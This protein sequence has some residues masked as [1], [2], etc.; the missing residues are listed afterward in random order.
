MNI[1]VDVCFQV[2]EKFYSWP[3]SFFHVQLSQQTFL[4]LWTITPALQFMLICSI[5]LQAWE[6][7]ISSL[8]SAYVSWLF[9]AYGHVMNFVVMFI[10]RNSSVGPNRYCRQGYRKDSYWWT[11]HEE[12]SQTFCESKH[13]KFKAFS[14][15]GPSVKYA[16]ASWLACRYDQAAWKRHPQNH[17]LLW[18]TILN[19]KQIMAMCHHIKNKFLWKTMTWCWSKCTSS[20]AT[21]NSWL[22]LWECIIQ[23]S[24]L[25]IWNMSALGWVFSFNWRFV[26]KCFG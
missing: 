8:S 19:W 26:L 18:Y 9:F 22:H 15:Q 20:V 5:F 21:R 7:V 14:P 25:F 10:W 1:T 3:F 24:F 23:N 17:N 6:S 16:E 13:S 4:F 2:D 12:P 11:T